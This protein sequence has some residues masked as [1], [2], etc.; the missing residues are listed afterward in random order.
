[1][2]KTRHFWAVFHFMKSKHFQIDFH[3]EPSIS[4]LKHKNGDQLNIC[5][6]KSIEMC[7]S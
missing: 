6:V 2:W 7:G 1:M 3:D 5:K 4:V